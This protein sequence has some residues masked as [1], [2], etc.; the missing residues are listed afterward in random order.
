[1]VSSTLKIDAILP[2]P[3]VFSMNRETIGRRYPFVFFIS[4]GVVPISLWM[5]T[6]E[7]TMWFWQS[8]LSMVDGLMK[9]LGQTIINDSF[10]SFSFGQVCFG[11]H[12]GEP[13]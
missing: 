10:I 13:H 8:D 2:N 11:N 1:M 7:M 4:I 3:D 6:T 5:W 12:L 9:F